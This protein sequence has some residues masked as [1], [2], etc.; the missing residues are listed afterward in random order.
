MAEQDSEIA[1]HH[2]RCECGG[3][4]YKVVGALR[5]VWNCHCARCKRI[6][7]H[8]FAATAAVVSA[9]TITETTLRW[10]SPEPTV[11]YG[12]CGTC[13]SSLFWRTTAR[14]ESISICAGTLNSPTGLTTTQAWW[15][16]TASDYH[17]RP[18]VREFPT[19]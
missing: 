17:E 14:P 7:G 11:A 9:I 12:F 13:G 18:A 4:E 8:H 6:T 15:T 10:Y 16:S 5:D 2:G 1:T 3:V 19:E